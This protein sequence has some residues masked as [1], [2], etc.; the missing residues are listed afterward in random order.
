MHTIA[1]KSYLWVL[2]WNWGVWRPHGWVNLTDQ[3]NCHASVSSYRHSIYLEMSSSWTYRRISGGY[4]KVS[5]PRE[6]GNQVSPKG[7]FS[8][9]WQKGH[10]V[11]QLTYTCGTYQHMKAHAGL[12]GPSVQVLYVSKWMLASML[13]LLTSSPTLKSLQSRSFLHTTPH[14]SYNL[15]PLAILSLLLAV[16][17]LLLSFFFF[18]LLT[19]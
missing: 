7:Y 16:P 18:L 15:A 9:L 11:L 2:D 12:Q 4:I 17:S 8:Y 14:F 10:M 5:I 13:V 1:W 3:L 19:L 6:L